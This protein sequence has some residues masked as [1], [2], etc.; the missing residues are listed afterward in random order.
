MTT[1]TKLTLV[2]PPH[3]LNI[4]PAHPFFG[5]YCHRC[6]KR[7]SWCWIPFIIIL[8]STVPSTTILCTWLWIRTRLWTW[9]PILC[10]SSPIILYLPAILFTILQQPILLPICFT[11]VSKLTWILAVFGE[12]ARFVEVMH[13]TTALTQDCIGEIK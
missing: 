4:E 3:D 11:C 7:N 5:R 10:W 9:L 13:P 12:T 6:R 8:L 1:R 2:N